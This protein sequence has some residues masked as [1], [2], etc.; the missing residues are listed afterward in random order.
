MS[1]FFLLEGSHLLNE[2]L[3]MIGPVHR[4]HLTILE[5]SNPMLLGIAG[6]LHVVSYPFTLLCHLVCLLFNRIN[7]SLSIP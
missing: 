2:T 3:N 7:T 4:L 1:P 6:I 5:N